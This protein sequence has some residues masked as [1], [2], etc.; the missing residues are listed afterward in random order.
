MLLSKPFK[1]HLIVQSYS[2]LRSL[3]LRALFTDTVQ[4]H[5]CDVS[6]RRRKK[7]KHSWLVIRLTAS[8]MFPWFPLIMTQ[9]KTI[10]RVDGS[11]C[12]TVIV[13][14]MCSTTLPL[15]TVSQFHYQFFL[16]LFAWLKTK[17]HIEKGVMD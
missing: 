13:L 3:R 12:Q 4:L 10:F 5:Q 17:Q 16:K 6:N 7:I 11:H 15:V 1:I 8:W 9:N 14:K 2:C